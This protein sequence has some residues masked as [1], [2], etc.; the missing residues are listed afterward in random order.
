MT[1]MFKQCYPNNISWV[2]TGEAA[3]QRTSVAT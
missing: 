1:R 2:L 3:C